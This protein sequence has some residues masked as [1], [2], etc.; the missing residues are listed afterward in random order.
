MNIT[1][2]RQKTEYW[3]YIQPVLLMLFFK[4]VQRLLFCFT[5]F[6]LSRYQAWSWR[7]IKN[8]CFTRFRRLLQKSFY[9]AK[10]WIYLWNNSSRIWTWSFRLFFDFASEVFIS[11]IFKKNCL[12]VLESVNFILKNST[13]IF[14]L[15]MFRY[16]LVQIFRWLSNIIEY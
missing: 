13:L 2:R 14:R 4:C 1:E 8:H 12:F 15:Y 5:Y 3:G 16:F 7:H 11:K 9:R 6:T 10:V